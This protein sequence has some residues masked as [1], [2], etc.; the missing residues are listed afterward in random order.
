ME[1]IYD[2]N[3]VGPASTYKKRLSDGLIVFFKSEKR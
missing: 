3:F 2:L 1:P